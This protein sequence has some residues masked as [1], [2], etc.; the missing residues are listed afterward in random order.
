MDEF[1]KKLDEFFADR[2]NFDEEGYAYDTDD[3]CIDA[4]L[5]PYDALVCEN[6]C[7]PY[8]KAVQM[9]DRGYEVT[10][11]ERDSF[12]WLSAGISKKVDGKWRMLIF[13]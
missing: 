6:T 5:D 4:G 8:G 9:R 1:I 2:D 13:G 3:R 10:C 12:G 7:V 11:L